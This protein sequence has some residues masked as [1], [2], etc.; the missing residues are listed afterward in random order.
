MTSGDASAY[1]NIAIDA[2]G[3]PA[4]SGCSVTDIAARGK[5][6]NWIQ[7]GNDLVHVG[8]DKI[9]VRIIVSTIPD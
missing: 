6:S 1:N 5:L 7:N 4:G 8:S 2:I 9:Y 3:A